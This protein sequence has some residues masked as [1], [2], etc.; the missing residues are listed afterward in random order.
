MLVWERDIMGNTYTVCEIRSKVRILMWTKINT[1][2]YHIE[3]EGGNVKAHHG[4]QGFLCLVEC[5]YCLLAL[6]LYKIH[7][8]GLVNKVPEHCILTLQNWPPKP[9]LICSYP[10]KLFSSINRHGSGRNKKGTLYLWK[11]LLNIPFTLRS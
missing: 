1:I 6:L 2:Y 10:L 9:L 3:R 8:S 7:V 4:F 5:L 11:F